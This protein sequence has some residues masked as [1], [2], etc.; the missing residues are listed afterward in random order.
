MLKTLDFKCF[1]CGYEFE[2]V[3]EDNEIVKCPQC[4]GSVRRLYGC[5]VL[6]KPIEGLDDDRDFKDSNEVAEFLREKRKRKLYF[7]D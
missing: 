6:K 7:Y 3:V 5:R 1:D 2:E 4:G